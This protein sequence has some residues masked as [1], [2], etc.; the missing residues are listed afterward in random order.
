MGCDFEFAIQILERGEAREQEPARRR[1]AL[2]WQFKTCCGGGPMS[3]AA[4]R[5][6][7]EHGI[8]GTYGLPKDAQKAERPAKR[9][10][11]DTDTESKT[12]EE[13]DEEEDPHLN[14]DNCLFYS[15][16]QVATTALLAQTDNETYKYCAKMLE[17]ARLLMELLRVAP[18]ATTLKGAWRLNEKNAAELAAQAT[19]EHI[20]RRMVRRLLDSLFATREEEDLVPHM[21][22]F[23]FAEPAA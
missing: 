14:P 4:T 3:L 11:L 7:N 13:E 10:K 6:A 5:A 20:W 17:D 23:L 9:R 1:D 16:E 2:T 8:W 15:C 18:P 19:N 22:S 12:D 21:C